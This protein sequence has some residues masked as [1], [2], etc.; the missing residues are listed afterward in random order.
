MNLECVKPLT[1]LWPVKYEGTPGLYKKIETVCSCG[2]N[3]CKD[4]CE[5]FTNAPEIYP[6]DKEWLMKD[7]LY[8]SNK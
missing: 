6:M 7:E 4:S 2:I 3:G 8:T 5:V 1:G